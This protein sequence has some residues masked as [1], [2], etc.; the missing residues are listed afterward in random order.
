VKYIVIKKFRDLQ[1]NHI[2]HEG[3]KFPHS[4]RVKKGRLEELA[5]DKNKLGTPLIQE[6]EEGE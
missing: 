6:I 2:Y 5:S 3:D 4:G 1:D